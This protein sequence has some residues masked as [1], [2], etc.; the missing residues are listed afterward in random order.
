MSDDAL[1]PLRDVCLPTAN[2]NPT[3]TPD[4]PFDYIDVSS[5]CNSTFAVTEPRR[6][7][8]GEAPS[9]ARREVR[10]GDVLFA[11]VRPALRR[12]AV[13]PESLDRQI[14]STG[15]CVLRPDP[16]RLNSG[17]LFAFV[18]T[19]GV[20]RRVEGLQTGATYPA[21]RDADLLDMQVPLPPL[22]EQRAI[23]AALGAV[24]A[25]AAAR[26][27]ETDAERERKVR[28]MHDLFTDARVRAE[29]KRDAHRMAALDDDRLF[30]FESGIWKGKKDPQVDCA[31]VRNTNFGRT[32]GSTSPTWP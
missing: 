27:R 20:R 24:R 18:L 4:E 9:R 11:T 28:L 6:M 13:V 25:A 8:G 17:Y 1:I 26:R 29:E 32:G 30:S 16:E 12:I 7:M 14:C 10:K 19:S 22:P 3:K 23:A 5:V 31:V 21:I 2:R 15:Y